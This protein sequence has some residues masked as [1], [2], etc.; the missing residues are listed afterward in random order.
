MAILDVFKKKKKIVK[1]APVKKKPVPA[2]AKATAGREKKM[3]K[4]LAPILKKNVKNQAF[5]VLI[6]PHITEKATNSEKENK[7][8]FRVFDNTNK[9]EVKKAVQSLYEVNVERVNIINIPKKKRRTGRKGEGWRR[10]Y[11]KAV[12]RIQKDQKIEIMPR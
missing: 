12:V 1:K 6:E 3:E 10:G 11:K 9:K 2:S 7:Y 8:I 5:R 4:K